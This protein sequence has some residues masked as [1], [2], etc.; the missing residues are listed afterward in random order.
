MNLKIR[1]V[2]RDIWYEC[3][4]LKVSQENGVSYVLPVVYSLAECCFETHLRPLAIMEEEQIVGFSMYA[5]DLDDGRFWI[6]VFMI[7]EQHQGKGYGR[8]GL[9]QVLQYIH[10]QEGT[11]EV[12]IGH[13]PDNLRAAHLYE[14]VGCKR[15]GECINGEVIRRYRFGE[16]QAGSH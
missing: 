8:E 12:I 4:A 11:S 3:T 2:D 5:K 1:P 14:A 6:Y 9:R 7:D 10:D 13:K 15:T 16:Q